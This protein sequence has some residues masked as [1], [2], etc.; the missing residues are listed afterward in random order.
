M[1]TLAKLKI[2]EYDYEKSHTTDPTG[3]KGFS[4]S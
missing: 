2:Q 3:Y 4:N 1:D